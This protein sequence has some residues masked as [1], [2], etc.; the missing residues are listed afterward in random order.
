MTMRRSAAIA[1]LATAALVLAGSSGGATRAGG[2]PLL[3]QSLLM[4]SLSKPLSGSDCR[5]KLGRRCYSPAQIAHAYG[6][7]QLHAAGIDGRGVTIAVIIP[8]GSPT[9][10]DDLHQFDQVFGV[11]GA[12]GVDPY[13]PIGEDPNLTVIQPVGPV[14][15]FDKK[16]DMVF[17]AQETTL[18]VEWA[19][20]VAP[21]ANILLVETPVDETTG[22]QGFPEIV[23]AEQYVLD[24]GLADVISQTFG[25]AEPSFPSPQA[26]LDL[27]SALVQAAQQNV[28]VVNASGDT[29]TTNFQPNGDLYTTQVNGWPSADPLVTSVGGTELSLDSTGARLSPDVVWNDSALLGQPA[30]SGGGLSSVFSRPAYQNGV[31]AIVGNSRGTPDISM[32]SGVDGAVWITYSFKGASAPFSLAGGTSAGTPQFAGVV[33]LA[34]QVAGRP[35]GA[36]NDAL[37]SL[38]YGSGL[39]DVTSGHNDAGPFTNSDGN[40]YD[41]PGFNAGPGYDLASGLG[42]IDAPRFVPALAAAACRGPGC[43]HS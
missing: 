31:S 6:L 16:S 15:A 28:T 14:P 32:S 34:D 26:I 27:R 12:K 21:K 3:A 25:A 42:T 9:I 36:I 24:H 17:W 22:V 2:G 30:A 7:D 10:A 11:I 13:P 41:V 20:V 8:F 38:S 19:H 40:T 1:I 18:D 29:G 5:K 39:V 37:Y 23:A 35:L 4:P 43:P 33:A